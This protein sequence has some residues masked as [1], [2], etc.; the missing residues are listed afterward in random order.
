MPFTTRL[1]ALLLILSFKLSTKAQEYIVFEKQ[2]GINSKLILPELS[3]SQNDI[4]LKSVDTN[5]YIFNFL[6]KGTDK[7]KWGNIN[8]ILQ[9]YDDPN[10]PFIDNI[11]ITAVPI[12]KP[13][14][15]IIL[16]KITKEDFSKVKQVTN[17]ELLIRSLPDLYIHL[18]KTGANQPRFYTKMPT[19][20]TLEY[21]L[22]IKDENVY[23]EIQQKVLVTKF[24]LGYLGAYFPNQFK[25]GFL[26]YL[27]NYSPLN[28][29]RLLKTYR[30]QELQDKI[31]EMRE[32]PL[33]NLI[34]DRIYL[35]SID[36][37]PSLKKYVFNYWEYPNG[38]GD[39]E[40]IY[41]KPAKLAQY[42][43]SLGSFSFLP[44]IGIINCTLDYYLKNKV[45]FDQK[46]NFQIMSI[47]SLSFETFKKNYNDSL[48]K[49]NGP[50][51]GYNY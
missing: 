50:V 48:P 15:K 11:L 23:Y 40:T 19:L 4:V 39:I 8:P 6:Y 9:K 33:K 3:L 1:I 37:M 5:V 17:E 22:I 35:S 47:N 25:D 13:G 14:E 41:L 49:P 31:K 34:Y 36:T 26:N 29:R 24:N 45:L 43:P 20:K 16:K 44:R 2:K 28:S 46:I 51:A 32:T 38:D 30:Y 10:K 7:L 18:T 27:E 42:H 12:V 21:R